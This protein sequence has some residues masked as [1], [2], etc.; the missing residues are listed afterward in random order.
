MTHWPLR[1]RRRCADSRALWWDAAEATALIVQ[2]IAEI[3]AGEP[4][5][6]HR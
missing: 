1:I 6:P 2:H 5:V 3:T 4:E